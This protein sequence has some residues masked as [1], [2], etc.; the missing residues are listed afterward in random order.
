MG[1]VNKSNRKGVACMSR[2]ALSK[3][4]SDGS[5][6]KEAI[7]EVAEGKRQ[8]YNAIL[9]TYNGITAPILWWAKELGMVPSTLSRRLKKTNWD[10]EAACATPVRPCPKDGITF[11]G[12]THSVREWASIYGL[13]APTVQ[14]RLRSGWSIEQALTMPPDESKQRIRKCRK[15]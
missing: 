11:R 5:N 8:R 14:S 9:L 1:A 4:G 15:H 10:L 7:A 13:A 12:E 3:R 2:I 6:A